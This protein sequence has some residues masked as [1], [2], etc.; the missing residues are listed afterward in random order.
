MNKR[1]GWLIVLLIISVLS[2]VLSGCNSSQVTAPTPPAKQ[3]TRTVVDQLGKTVTIPK[4]P[5]R[6]VCLQHHT[7]DIILELQAGDKLVGV[8]NKWQSLISPTLGDIYPR[9][10]ELPTPGDLETVNIEA[11]TKLNPDLVLVTHYMP[12]NV[13]EQIEKL[14]IP[15][16][17]VSLYKADYE[18]ASKLNPNLKD[19]DNAYTEGF[20]E[21]L[22]LIGSIMGKEQKAA[23][24]VE[25]ALK[26][27]EIVKE[28]LKD[29]PSNEKVSCYMANPDLFTYGT[30]K[31]T[32]VIIDRAG[33][34]N[35]AEGISGYKQ[36][37]LEQI[38]AWNPQVIFVQDRYEKV[39]EEI[40]TNPAWQG[41]EA[42]KSDKVYIAPE[43][44]KPWGHPCP[45][46]MALGE[47]WLAKKLYPDK[48]AD[49]DLQTTVNDFYTRFY[50]VPYQGKH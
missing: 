42:V 4:D 32:G 39:A 1:Y 25:Y 34:R 47:L 16:V 10:K 7:L 18:Q 23:E 12:K 8:I 45:E 46:S 3:E 37:T 27:R 24:L 40:K 29:I 20:K 43:Y 28:R 2:T 35:V 36:V 38:M 31:Y 6:V 30:G 14:G 21:G 13:I 17:A 5:K 44:A 15:V 9:L 41:I 11:L 19:P 22:A 48:F 26:N 33:G 49:I 50:G